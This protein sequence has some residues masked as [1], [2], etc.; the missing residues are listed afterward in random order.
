VYVSENGNIQS[1]LTIE[2]IQWAFLSGYAANWHPLTWISHML[3]IEFFGSQP[4]WHHLTNL[5]FHLATTLLLFFVLD[6][7]THA[8]WPSAFVAALFAL[9]PLHVESVAWVAERKDV[10]SA[11][12]WMLTLGA[13]V[14][15]AERPGVKRYCAVIICFSL[16][17]LS[18]PML[19]TLPFVLFLLDYWP[20]RR[21]DPDKNKPVR[22]PVSPNKRKRL[23]KHAPVKINKL[24][25]PYKRFGIPALIREKIPLLLL[26]G[27]SSIVT[28]LVQQHGGAMRSLELFPLTDRVK[29][30]LISYVMYIGK[31]LW[32]DN[33]AILYPYPESWPLWELWGAGLLLVLITLLVIRAAERFPYLSIGWLWYLGTLVPVIGIVQVGSQAMADR[34]TYIPIIGL[35]IIVSWGVPEL[36]RTWRHRNEILAVSS[37]LL[38]LCLSVATWTQVGYWRNSLTVFNHT[39]KVTD[40]NSI[41]YASRG[42]I[43]NRLGNYAQA[44]ED[45][46]KAVEFSPKYDEAYNNRGVSRAKLGHHTQ[47]LEDFSRAIEINPTYSEAY[48]NRGILYGL[49]GKFNQSISDLDKAIQINADYVEAYN[50]RG[51]SYQNL[52]NHRQARDDFSRAIELNPGYAQAY[53][54]RAIS[55]EALGMKSEA[56]EDLKKATQLGHRGARERL[57][58]R[59]N[60]L[61]FSPR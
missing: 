54:N 48:R 12:F 16:G 3:D 37:V 4:R 46:D 29:N 20:L 58:D 36:L 22:E 32:P 27:V 34:Y 42:A 9:H 28:Y 17:L 47:G 45:Y 5:I 52:G 57:M 7:M 50:D 59:M 26:A 18:K 41:I 38:L 31:T 43:Y 30:A 2:G 1:G 55:S 61:D 56:L 19:V 11:F 35:F 8:L 6:R 33:L 40:R 53:A 21:I 15:Y 51:F 49:I 14:L 39:L 24:T 60:L 44:I 25:N 23:E 13:Y 10:L